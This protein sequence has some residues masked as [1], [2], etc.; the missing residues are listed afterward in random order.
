MSRKEK[1]AFYLTPEKKALL[2]R[3]Y[4]EDGSRSLTAFIEN[5][6]DFYL[7]YL[8]ANSAGL[9]LPASLKSYLDGRLGQ[10]EDRLSSLTF[11]QAVEQ[12]MVAGI[13]A[14]AFQFSEDDLHRRRAESVNNVKKTN[15]RISLEQRVRE[16]WEEDDEW[17][18]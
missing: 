11:K 1:F 2:E 6:V 14:D 7:D 17:Q 9:F 12:D 18:D 13:L 16:A 5:A 3:R 4:Q 10:L 15:G 8:S